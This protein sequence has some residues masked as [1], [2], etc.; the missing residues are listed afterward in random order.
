MELLAFAVL[1]ASHTHQ[2]RLRLDDTER[3]TL[4][5]GAEARHGLAQRQ[6][7]VACEAQPLGDHGGSRRGR[8]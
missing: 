5:V 1:L 7:G 4:G 2:I 6:G 3:D 8:T